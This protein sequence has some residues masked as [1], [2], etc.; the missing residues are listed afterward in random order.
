M[1]TTGHIRD[2]SFLDALLLP[3]RVS[4]RLSRKQGGWVEIDWCVVLYR[5]QIRFHVSPTLP[6]YDLR[7]ELL[8]V[9]DFTHNLEWS[10][11]CTQ[12]VRRIGYEFTTVRVARHLSGCKIL[13]A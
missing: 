1:G 7:V 9:V 5:P 11:V 4:R 13:K 8:R 3:F 2:F 12:G 10:K 6:R